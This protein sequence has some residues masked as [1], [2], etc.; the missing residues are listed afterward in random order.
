FNYII[1]SRPGEAFSCIHSDECQGGCGTSKACRYCGAA[2]SIV[3]SQEKNIQITKECRIVTCI[4]DEHISLDLSVTV[5]PLKVDEKNYTILVIS[6]ISDQK[7]KNALEKIFFH[8]VLN[9]ATSIYGFLRLLNQFE[10]I[11]EIKEIMPRVESASNVLIEQIN[12]QR[13]LIN[14]ENGELKLNIESFNTLDMINECLNIVSDMTIKNEVQV[15]IDDN[16][17]S[18]TIESCKITLKRVLVNLLKNALE[19]SKQNQ[20]V[21]VGCNFVNNKVSF[22][23]YND[24]FIPEY[25]QLQIFNRSF[26]TKSSG[27]GLGTYSIKLLTNKYLKGNVSFKSSL[28]EGTIF[29]IEFNESYI[30]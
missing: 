5:T 20:Q 22:W 8:D 3:E 25:V 27:R 9:T 21:V 26:S 28:E 17:Y 7:R 15:K 1:G 10:K 12:E 11:N 18:G 2:Q 24:T 13:E 14:A 6:D 16:S 30:K 4:D 29:T 19:A 23:V